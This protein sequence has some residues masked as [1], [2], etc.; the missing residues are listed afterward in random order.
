MNYY[1]LIISLLLPIITL[2]LITYYYKVIITYC[3]IITTSLLH[4]YYIIITSLLPREN[5]VI[6]IPLLRIMQRVGLHYCIIITFHY[7][8]ITPGFIITHY[9]LFQSPE[10]ADE[11]PARRK[12][13]TLP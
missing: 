2:A 5:H 10:L 4:H 12:L 6:M 9:Y 3:Y 13:L 11:A 8:I 7:V 1:C